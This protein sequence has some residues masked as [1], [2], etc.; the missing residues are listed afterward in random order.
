MTQT[1]TKLYIV[2]HGETVWNTQ[3]RLQGQKDSP[4][5]QSGIDQAKELGNALAHVHFDSI[6]SSDLSRAQKTAELICLQKDIV[7]KTTEAIREQAYGRF[8]GVELEK[9]REELKDMFEM[10]KTI[11]DKQILEHRMDEKA[12]TPNEVISRFITFLR[13]I[14]VAYT[15]KN[16]LIVTH[17]AVM[18][19]LLIHLGFGTWHE[20][21]GHAVSN[22][23][24]I[25]LESDGV[26]FF[27]KEAHGI[28][29]AKTT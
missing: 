6:F 5:T 16:V 20:L 13:E 2:R 14:A 18:R 7:V 28:L 19:Y 9:F 21:S 4:L 22:G 27:V 11:S 26:D 23:A 3:K 29:K 1:T 8:E 12:E 10:F 24:Y 17:G 15:G 25:I